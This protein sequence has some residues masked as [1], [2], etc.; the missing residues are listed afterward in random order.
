MAHARIRASHGAG[1]AFARIYC[2]RWYWHTLAQLA[3]LLA[4]SGIVCGQSPAIPDPPRLT[5]TAIPADGVVGVRLSHAE[6]VNPAVTGQYPIEVLDAAGNAVGGRLAPGVGPYVVWHPDSALAVGEVLVV[7]IAPDY[8]NPWLRADLPF[9]VVEPL[10]T[11]EPPNA[12]VNVEL[13]DVGTVT[14]Q[15]CGD[16]CF[17]TYR[18]WGVNARLTATFQGTPA[19]Q[20]QYVYAFSWPRNEPMFWSEEPSITVL[21]QY[22][23]G[24]AFHPCRTLWAYPLVGGDSVAIAEGCVAEDSLVPHGEEHPP[25]DDVLDYDRCPDPPNLLH[26]DW[27]EVNQSKCLKQLAACPGY[28]DICTIESDIPGN[29][30]Q[31]DAGSY[32]R[33]GTLSEDGCQA[34]SSRG[35]PSSLAV[36]L[37]WMVFLLL[38]RPRRHQGSY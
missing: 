19:Q 29:S 9:S 30:N 28:S 25:L 20:G 26:Q 3:A 15:C 5:S 37:F 23:G 6:S 7:E 33:A 22:E 16:N 36:L 10:G 8:P 12:E 32:R 34:A 31:D 21:P 11:A 14:T 38:R 17:E 2:V 1:M 13:S 4:L 24:P 35:S 27:C 18:S